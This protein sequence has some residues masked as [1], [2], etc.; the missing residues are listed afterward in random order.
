[1][2]VLVFSSLYPNTAQPRHGIFIEQ[3]VRRLH[4][5]GLAV[6]V[7]APV[8]WFPSTHPRFGSY[9][10][11]AAVPRR[12]QRHAIDVL[13][14]RYPVVPKVGMTIAPALMAAAT[15]PMLRRLV[16]TADYD[17]MDAHYFYPDG[18]AAVW[19]ARRLGLPVAVTARGSDIN[20]IGNYRL[21][22]RMLRWAARKADSVITVSDALRVRFGELGADAS[23]ISVLTN[24]VDLELFRPE[25]DGG[26][27]EVDTL[28]SV[29]NLTENKGH[30]LVIDALA[31]LPHKQ[32]IVVGDG[33]MRGELTRQVDARGLSDRVQ[34]RG[35]MPQ[36][37]LRQLYAQA[38]TLVLASASE[39][40]PNVVL[41]SLA[42]GTPV[43]ATPV[44]G[45]PEVMTAPEA[46]VLLKTRSA[47]AIAEAVERLDR[48]RPATAEVRAFAERFGWV[49]TTQQQIALY[50][51]VARRK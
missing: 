26:A 40:M 46:G 12:D 33:P 21:P 27:V 45:V 50:T 4:E 36:E 6:S 22:R 16:A 17:L 24:G 32:L 42:C 14:P 3:R 10:T 37:A 47:T 43:V 5:A 48:R 8:P 30:H 1:M 18:V 51:D 34:F 20:V 29:G 11:L 25:D 31:L 35:V 41:E 39:G 2:R 23:E 28:L 19:L 7:V 9:A 44:G 13:Y 15:L 38:G 49:S